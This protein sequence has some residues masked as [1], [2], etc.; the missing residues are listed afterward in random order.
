MPGQIG[1]AGFN[2]LTY[3]P[4]IDFDINANMMIV[5]SVTSLR[6]ANDFIPLVIVILHVDSEALGGRLVAHI[7]DAEHAP[8]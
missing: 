7:N 5:R 3:L 2:L 8:A 4:A 1:S 6:D